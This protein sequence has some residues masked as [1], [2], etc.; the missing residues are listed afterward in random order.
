MYLVADL[1]I[2]LNVKK[3]QVRIYRVREVAMPVEGPTF[4]LRGPHIA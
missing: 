3:Q 1:E 2:S 4:P